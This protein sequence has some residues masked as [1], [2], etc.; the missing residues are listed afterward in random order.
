MDKDNFLEEFKNRLKRKCLKDKYIMNDEYEEKLHNNISIIFNYKFNQSNEGEL[1]YKIEFY[2][3]LSSFII[4][5]FA[6][7]IIYVINKYIS[8]KYE[9]NDFEMKK[10]NR[11]KSIEQ[12]RSKIENINPEDEKMIEW[13]YLKLMKETKFMERTIIAKNIEDFLRIEKI[14]SNTKRRI[15]ELDLIKEHK[16]R[17]EIIQNFYNCKDKLLKNNF[18]G[19]KNK[20]IKYA[21]ENDWKVRNEEIQAK[22]N[23]QVDDI[24]LTETRTIKPRKKSNQNIKVKKCALI[25]KKEG[26]NG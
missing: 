2:N 6:L 22:F 18:I 19:H 24:P 25:S 5:D 20:L 12:F 9:I 26:E 7:Y 17:I 15:D 10:R 11:I 3:E 14:V 21:Q 23:Y 8:N 4:K 13:V 1:D 16:N